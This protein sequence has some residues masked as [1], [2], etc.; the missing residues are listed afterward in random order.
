MSNRGSVEYSTHRTWSVRPH[1]ITLADGQPVVA[2]DGV[3]RCDMKQKLRQSV[4]GEVRL[5]AELLFF[6]RTGTQ[7]DCL[8]FATFKF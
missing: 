6:R 2:Q 1:E 8:L 5:T 3:G 4:V 7:Y